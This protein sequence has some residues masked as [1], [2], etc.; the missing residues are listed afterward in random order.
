MK[1]SEKKQN[2]FI[3]NVVSCRGER[4]KF[5]RLGMKVEVGED[6]D[7]GTIVGFNIRGNF[8]VKFANELKHGKK[9]KNCHP[10]Y[11]M[12]YFDENNN[13]IASF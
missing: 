7:V 12:R 1:F 11:K 5:V 9:S 13:L 8:D 3:D 2:E 4:F 6:K 10:T